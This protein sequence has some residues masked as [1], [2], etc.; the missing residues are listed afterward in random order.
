MTGLGRGTAKPFRQQVDAATGCVSVVVKHNRQLFAPGNIYFKT[1]LRMGSQSMLDVW[2]ARY[3]LDRTGKRGGG[4][5]C[6]VVVDM[7]SLSMRH[8]TIPR[9]TALTGCKNAC[10]FVE[11]FAQLF[12]ERHDLRPARAADY[13]VPVTPLVTAEKMGRRRMTFG[14]QRLHM[15]PQMSSRRGKRNAIGSTTNA[16]F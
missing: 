5:D 3:F 7:E 6:P 15:P 16:I 10:L 1:L 14:T 13:G 12:A 11:K 2:L 8:R 4:L 9:T